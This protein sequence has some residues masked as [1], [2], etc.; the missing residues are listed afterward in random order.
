MANKLKRGVVIR[1]GVTQPRYSKG[2]KL[3]L[4]IRE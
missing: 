4:L 1:F 2:S 3:K